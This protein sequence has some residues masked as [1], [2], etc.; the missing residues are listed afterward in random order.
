MLL[1]SGFR[2]SAFD[3]M[4]FADWNP[5]AWYSPAMTWCVQEGYFEGTDRNTIEAE[6]PITRAEFLAVMVRF[7]H[8]TGA[9]D[10]SFLKDVSSADW[11]YHSVSAGYAA[12][13]TNGISETSFAPHQNITRE[14]AFTMYIRAMQPSGI[15]SVSLSRF[16]DAVQISSWAYHSVSL[17]VSLDVIEGYED[18]TL[19]PGKEISRA[20][21]AQML[22]RSG[23]L[24]RPGMQNGYTEEERALIA[25]MNQTECITVSIDTELW[26]SAQDGGAA[27][28]IRYDK[29]NTSRAAITLYL[30]DASGG[31]VKELFH[32]ALRPGETV[33]RITLDNLPGRGTHSVRFTVVQETG[34]AIN[35]DAVLHI[36]YP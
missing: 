18:F 31:Y 15:S 34:A 30:K 2:A 19:R 3:R 35:F 20:E 11:F 4:A 5:G 21:V 14:Q 28:S 26:A 7:F 36:S 24:D 16:R 6:R 32:T 22:Y 13:I 25:E 12:Q 29:S 33:D 9:A 27:C 17:I 10:I 1:G 8:C 23:Y